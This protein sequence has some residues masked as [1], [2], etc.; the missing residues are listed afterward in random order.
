MQRSTLAR[1]YAPLA[2]VVAVQLLIIA[3]APSTAQRSRLTASGSGQGA[4]GAQSGSGGGADTGSGGTGGATG[5]TGTGGGT[6][7]TATGTGG[8]GGTTGVSGTGGGG[9]TGTGTGGGGVTGTGG[10]GGGGTGGGGTPP[11]V[12]T[13]GDTTH[14]VQGRQFDPTVD[15]YSPPCVPR[16]AGNNGGAT[17]QGV[18]ASTIKIVD[19]YA[20]YGTEVNTLLKAENSY[21]S[22]DQLRDL[23]ANWANF[24]N[25]HYELYGRKVQITVYQGQCQTI[26]PDEPCLRNEV[27]KIVQQEKPFWINWFGSLASLFYDQAS[28]DQTMN[29]GGTH[30]RDAFSAARAPYHWDVQETYDKMLTHFGEWYCAQLA[31]RPVQYAGTANP[32]DNLNGKPRVLGVI[33]TAD[34]EN[35]A[36]VNQS[37]LPTLA[38]CGVTVPPGHFYYYT[39]DISTAEQQRAAGVQAMRKAPE[40]TDVICICDLVAPTFLYEE[41]QQENYYPE[42]LLVGSG[43]MDDDTAGQSYDGTAAC[44]LGKNCNFDDAFGLSTIAAQVPPGQDAGSKAYAAG[45]GKGNG[46]PAAAIA[47]YWDN[48]NMIATLIQGA[49]PQL[50]PQNVQRGAFAAPPR[51]GGTTGHILRALGPDNYGWNQDD[52]I[53]YWSRTRPSPYNGKAG[54]Y[55]QVGGTRYTDQYPNGP[56][57]LPPKPR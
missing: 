47:E 28:K 36:A 18:T 55:V 31:H 33:G 49:G 44:P 41:E 15:Y 45:G 38:R 57:M 42:N 40:S 19:Y 6:G 46:A 1:R 50:V 10:G 3:L 16:F 51:G 29:T 14:C 22:I 53:T 48:V 17:Y 5:V 2:A 25:S 54:T 35:A 34:P 52:R 26:P 4:L 39:Q 20:D 9:G 8:G 24:V 12:P 13:K 37:L 11:G 7:V 56:L 27:D 21:V 43:F 30:F 23:D 32:T